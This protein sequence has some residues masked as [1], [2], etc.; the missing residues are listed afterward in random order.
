MRVAAPLSF[1]PTCFAPILSRMASQHPQLQIVSSYTDRFADLVGEGFD[2]AIRLGYLSDSNLVARRIGPI[3]G[4]L[5][6][7]PAYIEAHGAPETPD[8]IVKH[9]VVMRNAEKWQFMDG[10]EIVTVRP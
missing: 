2:C 6:A 5:V 7:S 3:F 1:G 9:Q 10:D 8:E 4:K